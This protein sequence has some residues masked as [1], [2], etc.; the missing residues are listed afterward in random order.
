LADEVRRGS[1]TETTTPT[2][3]THRSPHDGR[4]ATLGTNASGEEL[5]ADASNASG[6][7]N[8]LGVCLAA[9][10]R[11]TKSHAHARCQIAIA[12]EALTKASRGTAVPTA[13]PAHCN[14]WAG[15]SA[16]T[17][18]TAARHAGITRVHQRVS[19]GISGS[20]GRKGGGAN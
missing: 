12:A 10:A 1:A 5:R 16:A 11:L 3:A 6:R 8:T 7:C 4:G 9:G 14:A 18:R 13:A 20:K 19:A 2:G 15:R 17:R